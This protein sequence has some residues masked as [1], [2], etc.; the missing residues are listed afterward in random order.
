MT[1]RPLAE[2]Y[3]LTWLIGPAGEVGSEEIR[4]I[5][6]ASEGSSQAR[7]GTPL[8][9]GGPEASGDDSEAARPDTA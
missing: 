7:P 6:G 8:P 1:Y 5:S 4:Q 2:N 3:G 9:G